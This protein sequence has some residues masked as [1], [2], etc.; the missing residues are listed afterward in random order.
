MQDHPG[1][2]RASLCRPFDDTSRT[3][4]QPRDDRPLQKT[5]YAGQFAPARP[6]T[7]GANPATQDG[8]LSWTFL[9]SHRSTML[10]ST[11]AKRS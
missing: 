7:E 2:N 1:S 5:E 6:T 8:S 10:Q 3:V 9:G 4:F 11:G